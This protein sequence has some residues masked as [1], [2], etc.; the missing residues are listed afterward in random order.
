MSLKWSETRIGTNKLQNGEQSKIIVEIEGE[1]SIT[2]VNSK[3]HVENDDAK[4]EF[5][6]IEEM[7]LVVEKK[8][9]PPNYPSQQEQ[10]R[11][12]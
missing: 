6:Q 7:V 5:D 9:S 4:R 12:H 10:I 3:T 8:E 11:S 2:K 1:H